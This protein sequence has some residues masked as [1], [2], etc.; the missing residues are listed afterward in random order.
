VLLDS[1]NELAIEVLVAGEH[2]RPAYTI[3]HANADQ[4][5]ILG[6]LRLQHLADDDY[7]AEQITPR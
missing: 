5:A 6:A 7:L 2:A 4:R 1:S 3:T